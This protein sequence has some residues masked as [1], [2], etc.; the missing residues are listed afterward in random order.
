MDISFKGLIGESV[1]VYLDDVT[2]LSKKISNH[3][4]YLRHIFERYKKHSI[5]L[6][7]KKNIFSMSEGN[8]SGHIIRKSGISIKP[9]HIKAIT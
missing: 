7:P 2:I 4:H 9:K 6:N 8:L 5:S 1:L 3:L